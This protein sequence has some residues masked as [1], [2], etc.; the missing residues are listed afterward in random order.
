M[1]TSAVL[2]TVTDL[3]ELRRIGDSYAGIYTFTGEKPKAP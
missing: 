2:A 3:D 1:A